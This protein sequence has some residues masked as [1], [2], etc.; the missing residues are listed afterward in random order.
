M[1]LGDPI[2]KRQYGKVTMAPNHHPYTE[3]FPIHQRG[4][5]FQE[6]LL[7]PR[8]LIFGYLEPFYLCKNDG[9]LRLERTCISYDWD[10]VQPRRFK[11]N[12]YHAGAIRDLNN[13]TADTLFFGLIHQ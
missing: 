5:T 10:S 11:S 3:D 8:L 2:S 1:P 12:V 7:A 6:Y 13:S 9:G 4:W